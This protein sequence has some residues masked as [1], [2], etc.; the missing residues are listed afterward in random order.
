MHMNVRNVEF[1]N[2]LYTQATFVV[3]LNKLPNPPF[4]IKDFS[5]LQSLGY[6]TACSIC[7]PLF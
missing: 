2:V 3:L 4:H 5:S 1:H 6:V 7:C